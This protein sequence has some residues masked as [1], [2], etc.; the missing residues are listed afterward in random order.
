MQDIVRKQSDRLHQTIEE[1]IAVTKTKDAQRKVGTGRRWTQIV[2]LAVARLEQSTASRWRV[3]LGLGSTSPCRRT[4][5][6]LLLSTH[7]THNLS[8]AVTVTTYN[9][10]T[11]VR[12]L[13]FSPGSALF[14]NPRRPPAVAM[15]QSACASKRGRN[16]GRKG[17]TDMNTCAIS[18][19]PTPQSQ[20]QSQT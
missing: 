17:C 20:S 13:F 9:N 14:C 8:S 12:L 4:L 2:F 16:Q 18:S 1:S 6:L 3:G 5:G 15:S 19:A 11:K 7:Q 10:H